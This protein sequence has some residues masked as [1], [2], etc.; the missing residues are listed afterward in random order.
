MI[1]RLDQPRPALKGGGLHNNKESIPNR[2]QLLLL[3]GGE[4]WRRQ[5]AQHPCRQ[6]QIA[7]PAA[8]ACVNT[9]MQFIAPD[10]V[11]LDPWAAVAAEYSDVSPRRSDFSLPLPYQAS[12]ADVDD[13]FSAAPGAGDTPASGGGG[14]AAAAASGELESQQPA[15]SGSSKQGK[16][17]K[18]SGAY[19]PNVRELEAAARH[20]ALAPQLA[21]AAAAVHEWLRASAAPTVQQ[22]LQAGNIVPASQHGGADGAAKV[23]AVQPAGLEAAVGAEEAA[24]AAAAA[25]AGCQEQAAAAAEAA[26]G[27]TG[28]PAVSAA[29]QPAAGDAAMQPAGAGD[30]AA[31][32]AAEP[33][34][35]A[36]F[37]LRFTLKPKLQFAAGAAAEAAAGAAPRS[38]AGTAVAK[39]QQAG[40]ARA[41][42]HSQDVQQQQQQQL[43]QQLSVNLFNRLVSSAEGLS[44]GGSSSAA[45]GSSRSSRKVC[46]R[47]AWAGGHPVVLPPC[48]RF[49]MSDA[50]QL[51]PLVADA[52]GEL[53]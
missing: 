15:G 39:A 53:C 51:A 12:K 30:A 33:D 42:G 27:A 2:C 13:S 46:E 17:R 19:R 35:R 26:N 28:A 11:A 8:I 49:L 52:Q 48:S 6:L 1:G 36:M 50:R 44:Q 21:A 32:A 5:R 3:G 23:Q 20:A 16:K 45:G 37:E 24:A 4:Q 10:V 43:L 22:A 41:A 38:T 47:L 40:A 34:Y 7:A 9:S 14:M 25:A 29:A 31:D 18:Q